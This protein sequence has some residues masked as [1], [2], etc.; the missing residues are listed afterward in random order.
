MEGAGDEHP[1]QN[2][3]QPAP[4][5]VC[6]REDILLLTLVLCMKQATDTYI[7]C[8]C[9]TYGIISYSRCPHRSL[10]AMIHNHQVLHIHSTLEWN[11]STR[12]DKLHCQQVWPC[13]Q[14]SPKYI[15]RSCD[16]F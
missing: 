6:E 5:S 8:Y 10:V 13:K 2:Q 11:T 16:Y 14:S 1:L 4:G 12:Q 3:D 15:H 7:I 9:I